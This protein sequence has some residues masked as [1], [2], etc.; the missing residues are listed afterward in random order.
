MRTID[1]KLRGKGPSQAKDWTRTLS[2]WRTF[3]ADSF[4]ERARID[5]AACVR[6]ISSTIPSWHEAICGDAAAASGLVLRLGAPPRICARVDTA[7]TILLNTAFENAGAALVLSYALR[8][9]PLDPHERAR[10]AISWLVHNRKVQTCRPVDDR[11]QTEPGG[12]R[13]RPRR[14]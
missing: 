2:Y 6:R 5:V 3:A 1:P 11:P 12:P 14:S 9:M 8:R 4:D 7:M 13:M 10:L